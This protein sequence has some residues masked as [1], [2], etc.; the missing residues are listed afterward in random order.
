MDKAISVFFF[1]V[2]FIIIC[3]GLIVKGQ[4]IDY[5]KL[6]EL[7]EPGK[8]TGIIIPEVQKSIF[9]CKPIKNYKVC[10]GDTWENVAG[11]KINVLSVKGQI[12][13]W[14]LD[15][16]KTRYTLEMYC[17]NDNIPDLCKKLLKRGNGKCEIWSCNK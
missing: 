2:M 3:F 7:T 10:S 1:A 15:G 17:G 12:F 14:K 11:V 16:H 5:K 6:D 9:N 4:E 13:K 8:C